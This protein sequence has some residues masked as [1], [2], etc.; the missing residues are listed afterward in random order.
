MPSVKK[1]IEKV[2]IRIRNLKLETKKQY[3]ILAMYKGMQRM[4]DVVKNI[5]K[6]NAADVQERHNKKKQLMNEEKA[7][8]AERKKAKEV[9]N[10]V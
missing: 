9:A 2:S 8:V 7:K 10:E 4:Q 1:N 5:N 3:K 6:E